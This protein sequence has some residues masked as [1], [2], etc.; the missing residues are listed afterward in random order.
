MPCWCFENFFPLRIIQMV[1]QVI[2]DSFGSM[3]NGPKKIETTSFFVFQGQAPYSGR[4]SDCIA[5]PAHLGFSS[6]EAMEH[7]KGAEKQRPIS[8]LISKV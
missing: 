7:K 2:P 6:G 1:P 4:Y 8:F 5:V 3:E